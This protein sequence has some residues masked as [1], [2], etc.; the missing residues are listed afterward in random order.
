MAGSRA[1]Y[2]PAL[3]SAT[4]ISVARN[5]CAGGSFPPE[6]SDMMRILRLGAVAWLFACLLA[7]PALAQFETGSVLGTIHDNSGG[8]MPGVTVTLLGIDTGVS[9]TKVTDAEGNYEFFTI[10][11]GRYKV[12]AELT[13]F[14]GAVA[15]EVQVSVGNRVR[16]DL[17]MKVGSVSE[18]VEVTGT[19]ALLETDTS[20][21]GQAVTAKQAAELPL[22]RRGY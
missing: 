12:T 8:V 13:G 4:G 3:R 7:T 19:K 20:Q 5:A 6:R 21:P 16:V 18:S 17:S 10:K 15:D 9:T 11:P 2:A 14:S 22:I 1:V